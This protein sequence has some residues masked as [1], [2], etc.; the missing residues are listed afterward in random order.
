MTARA[1][2]ALL[3]G[4][5]QPPTFGGPKARPVSPHEALRGAVPE[6]LENRIPEERYRIY[7]MLRL[8][9]LEYP[10]ARLEVSGVVRTAQEVCLY[11]SLSRPPPTPSWPPPDGSCSL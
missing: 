8:R 11:E 6:A 5:R 2:L 9:V 4:R 3:E 7:K 1:E 10:A